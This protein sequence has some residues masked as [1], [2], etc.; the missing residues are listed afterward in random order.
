MHL[1]I[2][3]RTCYEYEQRERKGEK[4]K[5]TITSCNDRETMTDMPSRI[6]AAET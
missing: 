3:M 1:V 4:E 6:D 2:V 5:I